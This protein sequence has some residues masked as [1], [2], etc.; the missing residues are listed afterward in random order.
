VRVRFVDKTSGRGGRSG[1][2][3]H[4][5][6][7]CGAGAYAHTCTILTTEANEVVR[8]MN[9]RMPVILHPNDYGLWLRAEVRE[10]D[11]VRE[12]LR[13]IPGR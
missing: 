10:L 6:L 13:A 4:R 5:L 8:P 11:L 9:D 12:M 3:L 1:D 7:W 2:V